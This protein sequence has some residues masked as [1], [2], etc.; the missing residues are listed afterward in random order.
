MYIRWKAT[1]K[2]VVV[3]ELRVQLISEDFEK[4]NKANLALLAFDM[5]RSKNDAERAN[6]RK[7]WEF[8]LWAFELEKG[9]GVALKKSR[10]R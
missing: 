10:W 2:I 4:R 8:R 9:L 6:A 5:G 3:D 1:G 7:E